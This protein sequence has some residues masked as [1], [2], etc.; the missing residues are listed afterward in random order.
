[1]TGPLQDRDHGGP[2]VGYETETSNDALAGPWLVD[3][4]MFTAAKAGEVANDTATTPIRVARARR[5]ARTST[6]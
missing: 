5:A 6:Y 3:S 2:E 4:L 1:V